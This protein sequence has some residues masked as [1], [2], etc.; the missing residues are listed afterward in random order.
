MMVNR[1][2]VGGT[3]PRV[4]MAEDEPDI[5]LLLREAL[6]DAGFTVTWAEDGA[7][8]LEQEARDPCDALLTDV[9]MPNLDGVSLVRAVRER[10][11]ALPIVVL[12]G[13]M[14]SIDRQA[15]LLLGVPEDRMLE[16]PVPLEH[17]A[18]TLRLALNSGA[19]A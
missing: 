11:P 2:M 1:P 10:R 5:A 15:L 8:A 14:T 9:R 17:V 4:L 7:V 13:Y 19:R 18:E 3:A 12:S 16:K 6:E